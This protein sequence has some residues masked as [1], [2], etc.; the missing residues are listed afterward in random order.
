MGTFKAAMKGL[1]TPQTASY[2][3]AS[4]A[5][6]ALAISYA[7]AEGSEGNRRTT[8]VAKPK[9]FPAAGKQTFYGPISFNTDGPMKAKPMY[10]RQWV[11]AAS[12]AN[13]FPKTVI[14]PP[15]TNLVYPMPESDVGE[16]AA[17]V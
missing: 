2:H 16:G 14:M 9:A 10:G 12:A 5:G 1:S 3:A 6:A 8:L 4:A 15:N 13:I 11:E 7:M 17:V